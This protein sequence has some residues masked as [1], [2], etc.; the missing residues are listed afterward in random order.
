[1]EWLVARSWGSEPGAHLPNNQYLVPWPS[2]SAYQAQAHA[3]NADTIPLKVRLP[4]CPSHCCIKHVQV[5]VLK[6]IIVR[7][8]AHATPQ[9]KDQ[10]TGAAAQ[11]ASAKQALGAADTEA[12]QFRQAAEQA[13]QLLSRIPA[14]CMHSG[15]GLDAAHMARWLLE[16]AKSRDAAT[17]QLRAK[18]Q[19]CT[20]AYPVT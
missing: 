18:V 5:S 7:L 11:L 9:G 3:R 14:S 15:Q 10:G 2:F 12:R 17:A 1:M 13:Q 19:V 8:Q 16:E 20:A 4:K 6:R